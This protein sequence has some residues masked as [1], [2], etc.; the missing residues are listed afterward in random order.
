MALHCNRSGVHAARWLPPGAWQDCATPY[1]VDDDEPLTLGVD[2]GGSRSAPA[3]V[4][5]AGGPDG[6]RVALVEVRWQ[7][8][9]AV[10]KLTRAIEDLLS[11]GRRIRE[12]VADPMRFRRRH[13]L[14]HPA[15]AGGS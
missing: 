8:G 6:V 4:G 10:L 1:S 15:R 5:V 12:F 9:D 13:R 2:I 3:L 14:A 7:G 11:S